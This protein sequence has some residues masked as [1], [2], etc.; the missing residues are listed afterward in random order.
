VVD[1]VLNGRDEEATEILADVI[2]QMSAR[3]SSMSPLEL[4]QAWATVHDWAKRFERYID[5]GDDH[6]PMGLVNAGQRVYLSLCESQSQ[7]RLLHGD[8]EHYNV[9]FDSDRLAGD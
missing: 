4:P 5:S 3:A 7:P 9:V 6:I 8:L 1:L 2:Q